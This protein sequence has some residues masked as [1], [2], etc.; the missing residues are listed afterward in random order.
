MELQTGKR[1]DMG[2]LMETLCLGPPPP[3]M[4]PHRPP[5]E[6]GGLPAKT[7][8]DPRPRSENAMN[9]FVRVRP[10]LQEEKDNGMGTLDGL[11][12]SSS[13][14]GDDSAV[15]MRNATG[16][17]IAGFKG[18][19]GPDATNEDVFQRTVLPRIGTIMRGGTVTIFCYGYTGSG[20]T[21]TVLG[22]GDQGVQ[23]LH[24]LAAQHLLG[25]LVAASSLETSLFVSATACEVYGN[26]V[27]DL[28]GSEKLKCT[29]STD[30]KGQLQVPIPAVGVRACF[31]CRGSLPCPRIHT[32]PCVFLHR[33]EAQR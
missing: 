15:A 6:P 26:D 8:T 31:L 17:K 27:F 9:V 14:P 10:L 25:E 32:I 21:H 30:D 12:Q 16:D 4:T 11:A 29:L 2:Y 13:D 23:G 19:F 28:L 24:S 5:P 1:Y 22:Y 33:S 3:T 7:T 18:V 20:K